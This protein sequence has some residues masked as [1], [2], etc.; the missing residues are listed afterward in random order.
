MRRPLGVLAL[1]LGLTLATAAC[2]GD[3][4]DRTTLRVLAGPDLAVLE[5][6]LDELRSETG[7]ELAMDY[8]ADADTGEA[9]TGAGRNGGGQSDGG[10][11]DGVQGGGGR[12]ELAWLSTDRSFRLHHQDAAR[13][14]A[15]TPTMLSPVV[16]GLRP[17]AARALRAES[18][19]PRLTWADI[20]DAAAT[21]TVRFGMADPRQTGTGLAALVGVATAAAGTG[22]AL[23][24]KDVSCDRLR[25]F[26]SGQGLT[27]ASTR[28]LLA[29]FVA[30]PGTA[31]ALIT[32]E[33]DLLALNS[34]GRLKEKLEI[35]RPQDGTVL[36]DFP[37][38][39]LDPDRRAAYDK[40]VRWLRRDSVQRKIMRTAQRRPVNPS[41][42][43]E[44]Q[45]RA[46]VGNALY[47]PDRPG[48]LRRL[49]D[50]YG[51]PARR[52]ADQVIFL[53]DFSG[54][55]RGERMAELRRAFADLSGA[56]SS[57][58][59]A[60][61][62]FHQGER[63]TVVRFGGRVLEERTVTVRGRRDL[64]A[65]ADVVAS[66][67]YG[68]ATA[69]WTALDHGYRTASSVVADEPGRDVSIV[70]MTDGENNAGIT[71][72]EFVR[73]H[74]ARAAG[75]RASVHAYPVHFG[76][77]DAGALRRAAAETGGRMV[78]ARGSSLS[79]AF[80]EIRGCR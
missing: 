38:L 20:A 76:D 56:D 54:S 39:L 71:Y 77:A 72:E 42:A 5:P 12:Y 51:D 3:D 57:A 33:S 75:V 62:R 59:G 44:G 53:L 47:F 28:D 65:L 4:E 27:A 55:M 2:S 46:P 73:R 22:G 78:D 7:V 14:M 29:D 15:R 35:V 80:K 1:C 40:V 26:R 61:A 67:G 10:Q 18:G 41:V 48:V 16:V 25:G 24:E 31:N 70:L 37:L 21:G 63:L 49:L 30:R 43:R 52:I 69:V 36:A 50:D 19:G 45:L 17:E 8:R 13:G 68:D 23:R 32:Y 9:L 6:L 66:G 79:E 11:S 34:G 58:T 74:E 64:T 60:F